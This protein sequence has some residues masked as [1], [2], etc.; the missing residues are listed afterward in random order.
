MIV[1]TVFKLTDLLHL[2]PSSD[3]SQV[4]RLEE[5][6]FAGWPALE[7]RDVAGWRLR[8]SDGY[9]KRANSI[10]AL[11]P[12]CSDSMPGRSIPWKRPIR[13]AASGRPGG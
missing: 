7:T 1:I 13:S 2:S 4:R 11:G 9:T 5:L 12:G 10:N 6:A 8:F 3:L